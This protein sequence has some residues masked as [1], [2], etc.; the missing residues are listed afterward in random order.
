MNRDG[1]ERHRP[2]L[3]RGE[4]GAVLIQ[5]AV[6]A[7]VLCSVCA[8]VVDYGV[9]LVARA[10]AQNAADAGALS[11]AT[12]LAFDSMQAADVLQDAALTT[13]TAN[14][15]WLEPALAE[16]SA[17]GS[18]PCLVPGAP[19]PPGAADIRIAS[20]LT[21]I[22]TAIAATRS[23]RSSRSCQR[24]RPG[25]TRRLKR[26]RRANTTECLT[27]AI[28]DK[29]TG[30]S[31]GLAWSASPP[32]RFVKPSIR[33]SRVRQCERHGVQLRNGVQARDTTERRRESTPELALT[34]TR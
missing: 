7:V 13:A 30:P 26:R 31:T 17:V 14:T 1:A 18:P 33:R 24:G 20:S 25:C 27:L 10:Q 2:S 28:P 21:C 22:A 6:A 3:A 34:L 19:E 11:G 4:R 9:F 5:V 29:W 12:A 23:R 16:V 15:V 8:F 32:S